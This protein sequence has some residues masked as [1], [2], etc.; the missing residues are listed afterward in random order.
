MITD[1]DFHTHLSD[2][3]GNYQTAISVHYRFLE[4]EIARVY[5]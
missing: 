1:V 4:G 5:V 3:T 2:E